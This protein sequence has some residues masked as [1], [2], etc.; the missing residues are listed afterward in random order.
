MNERPF[1]NDP[2]SDIDDYTAIESEY[3]AEDDRWYPGKYTRRFLF[4]GLGAVATALD[5]A[6]Q[7]FDRFADRG[8]RLAEEWDD[9]VDDVRRQNADAGERAREYAR[10]G[11]NLLLDTVGVPNKGDVDTIN[12]KLNILSRKLDE[13]QLDLVTPARGTSPPPPEPPGGDAS[14]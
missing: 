9:R 6:G 11:V 12:V 13:L 3:P 8:E 14:I 10:S 7:T 4:A 5:T 1:T 2:T